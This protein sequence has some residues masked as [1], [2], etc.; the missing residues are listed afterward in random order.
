MDFKGLI[1]VVKH[2]SVGL[3][4]EVTRQMHTVEMLGKT[5][6]IEEEFFT[7]VAPGMRQDLSPAV[8]RWITMLDV[9]SQLLHV[10]DALLA[11][12]DSAA[13]Q[14]DKAESFLVCGLHVAPQALLVWEL[15]LVLTVG[16]QAGEHS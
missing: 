12:E 4:A 7:K 11:N 14:A 6:V 8:T 5:I 1:I 15:L 2:V 3:A 13:L 16:D 9:R 10:V